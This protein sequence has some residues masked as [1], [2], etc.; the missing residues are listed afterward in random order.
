MSPEPRYG[1]GYQKERERDLPGGPVVKTSPSNAAGTGLIPGPGAKIPHAS[2]PKN[3]N[4]KQ[5]QYCNKFNKDFTNGPHK[6]K[7]IF[8]KK[9]TSLVAQWLRIRLP[10]QGTRVRA[11]VQEDPT[12]RGATKPMN[13]N[14]WACALQPMSQNY[15]AHVPQLLK[16]AHQE[17]VLHNKRSHCNEPAHCNEE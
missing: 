9:R 1:K 16:P 5:K 12:C 7:K 3:Q 4:I 13:H 17:P 14:Y 11:L 15:W 10:T 6:K 8:K 2:R